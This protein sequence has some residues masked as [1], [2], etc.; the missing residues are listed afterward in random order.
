MKTLIEQVGEALEAKALERQAKLDEL[1]ARQTEIETISATE[2]RD[3]S[4]EELDSLKAIADELRSI[5]EESTSLEARKAELEAT[6]RAK[7]ESGKKLADAGAI[8]SRNVVSGISEPATYRA[9]NQREHSFLMDAA[10]A[11]VSGD[12][13]ARERIQRHM[14][15]TRDVGTGAFTGLVIPQYL[16]ELVAPNLRA[17]RPLA[18]NV[19][20]LTLPDDGM[21]VNIARIT[22]ATAVAAQGSEN[23]AVQETD[24]DDTLLTVDVRTYAGQ[25]DISRQ[26]IDR[27]TGIEDVVVQDLI[28]DYH[29]K[30]DS[31]IINGDASSGTHRGI[32]STSGIGAVTYTDASPTGAELFPKIFEA[33]SLVASSIFAPATALVMHSR[34]WNWLLKER[35]GSNRPLVVPEVNGPFNAFGVT[36]STFGAFVGNIGGVP[37]LIDNNLPTNLGAGTNEDI[38]LAVNLNELFLWEQPNSPLFL[39]FEETNGANLTVKAVVYGYSA[40]TAGRYP[41]ASATIGGTGLVTPAW[42]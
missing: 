22:T 33:T 29:T 14:A 24:M 19:R 36:E 38:I 23:A 42:A 7:A 15:E 12:F 35:D 31:A 9:D 3:A 28:A 8:S 34:R 25:Q 40:F 30:L 13:E 1:E 17:M 11:Q 37:V 32:R 41:G 26:A 2:K 6:Q 21:T 10:R 27:G 4:S 20:K 18:D 16:T 39:R 5:E